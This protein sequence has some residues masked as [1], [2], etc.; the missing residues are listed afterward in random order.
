MSK[1]FARLAAALWLLCAAPAFAQNADDVAIR[2]AVRTFETGWNNHDM[3]AM[4]Q[5]F[6]PDAEFVNIVGM[7]WRGLPD[8]K[9]AHQAM[10][11]TFFKTVPNRIEDLQARVVAPD[12]AIAVVR[13]K[14]GSFT[15]PDGLVHPESRDVMSMFLVK[16]DGRWLVAGVH[17]TPIDEM[18]IRF[19]P[20]ARRP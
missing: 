17:N 8:V 18:A 20:A 2:A 3:D 7:Y 1:T 10:H 16:R 12:A 5:A 14:K 9:R 15:S 13:W 4:F 11:D 19:D 6:T